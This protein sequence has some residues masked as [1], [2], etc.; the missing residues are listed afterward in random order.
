MTGTRASRWTFAMGG[1]FALTLCAGPGGG[2]NGHHRHD[3]RRRRRSAG[4]GPTRR[5]GLR[6]PPAD[7]A[8]STSR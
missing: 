6:D 4:S 1:L 5:N 2:A 3:Q 7:G 8:P